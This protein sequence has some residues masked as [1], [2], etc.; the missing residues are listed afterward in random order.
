MNNDLKTWLWM[1]AIFAVFGTLGLLIGDHQLR[2]A[3]GLALGCGLLG[4]IVGVA[5]G[6]TSARLKTNLDDSVRNGTL[7]GWL[8]SIVSSIWFYVT[9]G[10]DANDDPFMIAV[11]GSMGVMLLFTLIVMKAIYPQLIMFPD[12]QSDGLAEHQSRKEKGNG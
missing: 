7:A 9:L 6:V 3:E 11:L 10:M 1:T 5:A 4:G 12:A 2:V 8:I